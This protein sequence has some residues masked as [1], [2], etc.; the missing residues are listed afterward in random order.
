MSWGS[1]TSTFHLVHGRVMPVT[2]ASWKASLPMAPVATCPE[3]T[4]MGVPSI[5]ASWSGVI[6]VGRAGSG[7]DQDDAD[8]AGGPGVALG[9]VSGALLVAGEDE[10]QVGALVDGVED[11]QD[12]AAGV[13]EHVLDVEFAEA[14][15]EGLGAGH[16]DVAIGELGFVGPELG[17]VGVELGFL[18]LG[19]VLRHGA[20]S[21]Q[22]GGVPADLGP[23][24]A[25]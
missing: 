7:G 20:K 13:A 6:G 15:V 4:M 17:A 14:L 10:V 25:E 9:H 11:G 1:L 12:G 24:R 18:L 19:I 2:S 16:A 3:K 22:I 5:R 23:G 8:L 21:S